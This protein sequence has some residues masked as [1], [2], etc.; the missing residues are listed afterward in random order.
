MTKI[1]LVANDQ[2]LSASSS[3]TIASGDVNSVI[4]HIDF[5]EEWEG[6]GSSAVF[7]VDGKSEIYEIPLVEGD[8]VVPHEV[9]ADAGTL[10]IGARG[11][12]AD[13]EQTK[14]ST[15]V[16][17]KIKDG[18][19]TGNG[20]TV[21]PT[22][23][24]YQQLLTAYGNTQNAMA[25]IRKRFEDTLKKTHKTYELLWENTNPTSNFE[26]TDIRLGEDVMSKYSE[27][28]V[29]YMESD[30]N[31]VDSDYFYIKNRH[32]YDGNPIT[33]TPGGYLYTMCDHG[34][35]SNPHIRVVEVMTGYIRFDDCRYYHD[36]QFK[37]G[38][39][40]LIPCKI[41]GVNV[42]VR[43][44]IDDLVAA[45]VEGLFVP[46]DSDDEYEELLGRGEIDPK[47][48]YVFY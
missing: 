35:A 1:Y 12:N 30:A 5:S 21:P 41:Y 39:G 29:T 20:A 22:A 14:T 3:P 8:C 25:D 6:Y 24:V 31:N 9:L 34:L 32:E 44:N 2:L 16:K 40:S 43:T 37:V 27:F 4:T 45:A 42:N 10:F 28:M 33:G 18:A 38:N 15:L 26:G 17:Y 46:L 11:V 23:D 47:K 7:F 36:G 13:K 19:P 48:Y